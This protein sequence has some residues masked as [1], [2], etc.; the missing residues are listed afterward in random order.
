M[1]DRE[2]DNLISD[3][4]R[5]LQEIRRKDAH[6]RRLIIKQDR[7]YSEFWRLIDEARELVR[8]MGG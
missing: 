7:R 4:E 3:K 6:V 2:L 5:L 1:I 8:R